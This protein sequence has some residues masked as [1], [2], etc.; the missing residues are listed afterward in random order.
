M[1]VCVCV[2]VLKGD[3]SGVSWKG[4]HCMPIHGDPK[5]EVNT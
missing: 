4:Y 1:C 3:E 5:L 2:R